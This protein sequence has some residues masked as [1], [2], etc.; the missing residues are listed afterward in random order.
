VYHLYVIA[1][2]GRD[3]LKKKLA[4]ST[5]FAGIHYP[6]SGHLHGGYGR[7]VVVPPEGL[8]VTD[9]LANII[10]SLPMYPELPY[11]HIEK[12]VQIINN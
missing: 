6:V 1:C 12:V 5:V 8:P 10:L 7:Q 11:D 2:K 4:D 9:D 3:H